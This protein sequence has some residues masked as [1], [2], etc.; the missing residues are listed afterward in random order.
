MKNYH[1]VIN[2]DLSSKE[3]RN[4][5]IFKAYNGML[6]ALMIPDC[7]GVWRLGIVHKIKLD[8]RKFEVYVWQGG[9]ALCPDTQH[10]SCSI[11]YTDFY[12]LIYDKMMNQSVHPNFELLFLDIIS[13]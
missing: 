7:H 5:Y 2:L 9:I 10:L 1:K 12:C 13:I 11:I 4:F 8:M 3:T 6:Y